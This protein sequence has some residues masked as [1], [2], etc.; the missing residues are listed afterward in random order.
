MLNFF[1]TILPHRPQK[2]HS[3]KPK[4]EILNLC[5]NLN[6]MQTGMVHPQFPHQFPHAV[7]LLSKVFTVKIKK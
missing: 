6:N 5:A 3:N 4:A 1:L 7:S 2:K